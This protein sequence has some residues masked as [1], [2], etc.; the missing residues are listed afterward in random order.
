M[1]QE[2]LDNLMKWAV[3]NGL[4]INP[5]ISK[6]IRFTKACVKN[7]LDYCIGDKKIPNASSRK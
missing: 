5:G 4:K 7:P 3:D 6:A 1:L 2:D